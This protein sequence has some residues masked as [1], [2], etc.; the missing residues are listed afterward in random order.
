MKLVALLHKQKFGQMASSV[1]LCSTLPT[2]LQYE[3]EKHSGGNILRSEELQENYVGAL[4]FHLYFLSS[5]LS[6]LYRPFVFLC[7]YGEIIL[8]VNNYECI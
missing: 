1:Y 4:L 2:W 6:F 5:S 3:L 8:S 7:S